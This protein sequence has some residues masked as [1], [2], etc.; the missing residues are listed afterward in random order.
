MPSIKVIAA[1]FLLNK[2]L[3][4]ELRLAFPQTEFYEGPSGDMEAIKRFSSDA[5]ILLVGREK[6]DADFLTHCPRLKL[7][8]KYGVGIDNIDTDLLEKKGIALGWTGGVNKRSVAEMT[9][10]YLLLA[11]HNVFLC[12]NKLKNGEWHKNGGFCLENK[13]L[14]IIGFGHIGSEVARLLKGFGVQI[15]ANDILDKSREAEALHVCLATKEEIYEKCDFISLH[16]PY[17]K[18]TKQFFGKEI[19]EKCKPGL[20]LINCARG[21]LVEQNHILKA[22]NSGRMGGYY[23]DAFDPEPYLES[24]LIQHERFFGSPHIGGNSQEAVL[25]MG[26]SAIEHIRNYFMK[27]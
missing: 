5:E 17:T 2:T 11:A 22:L 24:E 9:V 7:L 6:M 27:L 1:S 10:G 19:I 16:L 13:K 21:E 15:L 18:E 8:V 12:G 23:A 20:I 26:R 14:G 4:G 25:N 3:V